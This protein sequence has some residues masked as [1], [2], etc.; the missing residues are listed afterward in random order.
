[1]A[2]VAPTSLNIIHEAFARRMKQACDANSALRKMGYSRELMVAHG[3]RSTASTILNRRK[4][5]R[6]VIE[7]QLA[8]APEDRIRAIYNRDMLWPERVRLMQRWADM[9][10]DMKLL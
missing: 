2:T 6:D 1:M 7:M 4:F 5:D 10:D 8:H 3:F 9:L